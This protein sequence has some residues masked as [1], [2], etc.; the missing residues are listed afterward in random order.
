MKSAADLSLLRCF[1]TVAIHESFSAAA[2]ALGIDQSTLSRQIQNLEASSGVRVFDRI[3]RGVALTAAGEEL[4]TLARPLLQDADMFMLRA[5]EIAQGSHAMVRIGATPQT[6]ESFLSPLLADF[7][8]REP[9]FQ[10]SLFEDNSENLLER[11]SRGH[12]H[13]A[14]S[15]PPSL[16][17]T[18]VPVYPLAPLA[19]VPRHNPLS[20]RKYLEVIDLVDEQLITFR[21]GYI[22]RRLL[23]GAAALE[24]FRPRILL[25]SGNSHI[26][27][28]LAEDGL[29]IAIAPSTLNLEGVGQA[30]LPIFHRG[31][32]LNLWMFIVWDSRRTLPPIANAF[33][34]HATQFSRIHYP[35]S[36]IPTIRRL[37]RLRPQVSGLAS[38]DGV[39]ESCVN[40]P[41]VQD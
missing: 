35:G 16:S 29:G 13:I 38:G 28:Q 14:V 19:V 7:R 2:K 39:D 9:G 4:L 33:I 17:L 10:F 41:P 5:S 18:G 40:T 26:L 25:E 20:S 15:S 22:T 30:I 27:L 32:P 8:R 36:T 12:I 21:Q 11:V 23:D 37:A 1:D 31:E 24:G 34:E 3:G 6:M